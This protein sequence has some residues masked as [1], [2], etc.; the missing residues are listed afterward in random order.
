MSPQP[1]FHQVTSRVAIWH[2]FDPQVKAELS[3]TLLQT[4]HGAFVV[5]PFAPVPAEIAALTAGG[6]AAVILTNGN[7]TR[8]ANDSSV[9]VFAR[10]AAHPELSL[11]QAQD[12]ASAALPPDLRA[13]P[14][15][16]A[17]TG[18]VALHYQAEG[19]TLVMG[20]ALI[21]MGSHG[22][23]FLPAKYCANPKLMRKSLRALLDYRFERILFAHGTPITTQARSRLE[24]LLEDG[25]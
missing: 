11:P 15:E 21:H 7:H 17:G 22:F 8:A 4:E 24:E 9:P 10:A 13:L 14:I 25:R 16:G 18:E 2:R 12:I 1:E 23:T 6:I 19:G 5:D 3:A 20:D